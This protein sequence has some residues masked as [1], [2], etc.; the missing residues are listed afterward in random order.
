HPAT[1][2]RGVK[3]VP[4]ATAVTVRPDGSLTERTYWRLQQ[5][6]AADAS[7]V[8]AAEARQRVRALVTDAVRKRLVSDVPLGAFL[9][10][11]IDST[12]VVGVMSRLMNQRVKTFTIGFDGDAAYDETAGARDVAARFNTDHTE[13]RVKPAAVDLVD[14]LVWHHD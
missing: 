14:R 4:P 5:R 12:I 9:S 7:P 8:D 13:F 10:A 11:G 1:M 6:A 2:Y 3:Q